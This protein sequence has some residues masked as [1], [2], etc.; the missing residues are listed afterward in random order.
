MRWTAPPPGRGSASESV[1][2]EATRIRRSSSWWQSRRLAS[3]SRSR[4]FKFTASE[5]LPFGP[6]LL[7]L[8]WPRSQAELERRQREARQHHQAGRSLSA[9][10]VHG[11]RTGGHPLYQDPRHQTSPVACPAARAAANEGRGNRAGKQA[12]AHGL[13]DDGQRR[14]LS[15][16]NSTR[17]IAESRRGTRSRRKTRCD[18]WKGLTAR[19]AEPVDPMIGTPH[20]GQS[21]DECELLTGTRS[22]EGIM[23]SGPVSRVNRPNTWLLR[24]AL[25]RAQSLDSPEP[26]THGPLPP[27]A[28]DAQESADRG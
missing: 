7:G 24:P 27:R 21:I 23:A 4:S 19:N 9:Q 6:R 14:V 5:S 12:C 20:L 28:S 15:R 17:E 8:D 3:T 22:A 10:L 25:R 2:D 11:G 18:G 1:A 26:S 13:G 16:A